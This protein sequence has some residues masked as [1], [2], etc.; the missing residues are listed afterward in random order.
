METL[1]TEKV[2]ILYQNNNE[3]NRIENY[4]KKFN[5]NIKYELIK[6]IKYDSNDNY[7]FNLSR[8]INFEN[9]YFKKYLLYY[10][11]YKL[12]KNQ[13]SH[14]KSIINIIEKAIKYNYESIT[15]IEFDVYFH[16]NYET[17]LPDY[18]ILIDNLI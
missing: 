13:I 14:I 8:T 17:I 9:E 1:Y 2:F 11:D 16:K 5:I 3:K 12:N 18:K 10:Q 4:L 7:I 6:S 15:I